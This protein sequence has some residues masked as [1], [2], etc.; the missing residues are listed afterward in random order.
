MV[1]GLD[2]VGGDGGYDLDLM[3]ASLRS[4]SD[5]VRVLLR[6]LVGRLADALGQRLEIERAGGFLRKSDEIKRVTIR[7]GDDQLDAVVDRGGLQCSVSRTSGGI[8]IR[9][10]KVAFAEWVRRLLSALQDEAAT[11]QAT[12]AALESLVIGDGA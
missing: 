4:D 3:A 7:L 9:S 2:P 5:D 10:E 6:A 12:R 1:G 11:S 8:R